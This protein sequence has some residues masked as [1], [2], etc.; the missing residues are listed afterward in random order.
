MSRMLV[1]RPDFDRTTRYIS[2]WAEKV[3]DFA[4]E[5]NVGV[6]DLHA[7]R[8]NRKVFESMLRKRRPSFVFLN[9]H[10][11]S[12]MVGGQNNEPLVQTGLNEEVLAETVTYALSCCSAKDLGP[13]AVRRG[14]GAFIGYREEFIFLFTEA[15]R[16][17]PDEDPLARNF[18]E[19]SNQVAVSLLKGHDAR[20]AHAN[21][22]QAFVRNIRKLLSSET[23]AADSSA[24]R[25]LFW[26]LR[27]QVCLGNGDATIV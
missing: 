20:T 18:F 14:K 12:D 11:D 8:A 10:G 17:R 16:T 22:K 15:Q 23:S 21:S 7:S 26:N 27:H 19:P 6:L 13:S 9:G 1:T 25:Y 3:I 5:K 24:V 2:G 4:K